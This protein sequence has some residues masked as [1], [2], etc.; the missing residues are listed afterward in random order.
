[1]QPSTTLSACAHCGT[2]P[3]HPLC[4]TA[5]KEPYRPI[6]Y[7]CGGTWHERKDDWIYCDKCPARYTHKR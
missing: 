7:R 4:E 5:T 2:I 6:H 3:C 1:M